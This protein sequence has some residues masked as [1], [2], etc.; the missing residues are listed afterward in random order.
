MSRLNRIAAVRRLDSTGSA[1]V[2]LTLVLPL[3]VL[4]IIGALD[5]AQLFNTTQG[6]AAATRAGADYA[7]N[8][9]TCQSGIDVLN[10]PQIT[11][12]CINGI[13][14]AAQNSYP[15]NPALTVANPSLAC[16]CDGDGGSITCGNYSCASQTPSRGNNEVF[17][18]V[19]ATEAFTPVVT[20]PGFPSTL[21][22][23]TEL[24]LQ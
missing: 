14:N 15:F 22:G 18:T 9:R 4:L 7:H 8:S 1:A 24:R 13:K 2:E 17:V 23:L 5:F 10:S 16:Y 11:T 12:A 20:L 19:T 6:L 21:N 3:L